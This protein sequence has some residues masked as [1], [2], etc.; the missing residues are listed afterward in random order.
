MKRFAAVWTALVCLILLVC[1]TG[2]H[3]DA[4]TGN[5]T[6]RITLDAMPTNLDP[7]L[8]ESDEALL[9]VRNAFEGLFR[10]DGGEIR[11]AACETWDVSGDGLT[12]TFTL[13]QGLTWSDGSPLTAADFR[14]GLV[15]AL[16]P[17]TKAPNAERLL[18]IV[19][20]PAV[21][22]GAADE[23]T[24]GIEATDDRTLILRLSQRDDS[25]PETLTYAMT[26]PCKESFFLEA[27]GRYGMASK[28]I[29][30]NGPF[31]LSQW[32]ESA[33]R[34][35]RNEHYVGDFPAKPAA[36]VLRFGGMD[37]ERI[38]SVNNDFSDLVSLSTQSA[39]LAEDARL[40]VRQFRD[41]TW[42]ALINPQASVLGDAAVSDAFRTALGTDLLEG[43]LPAQFQPTA[44]LIAGDL[45]VG[46]KRYD[47]LA[48]RPQ[49]SSANPT[50]AKQKL[51]AAL[52]PYGGHLPAI[53]LLYADT[54][55][56][57]QTASHLAQYLQKELGAVV[58]IEARPTAEVVQAVES[59]DYQMALCPF[60]AANGKAQTQLRSIL[61][62]LGAAENVIA[63]VDAMSDLAPDAG[64]E[65]LRRL[66]SQA[67]A[68]SRL[69]PLA[70]SGR[71]FAGSDALTD[72]EPDLAQ[73]LIPLYRAGKHN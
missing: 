4:S 5:K 60:T 10:A 23:A 28:Q 1:G 59:G 45:L 52:K 70:E 73:G 38:E 51:I 14:F 41:T 18:R 11:P 9:L 63:R 26:M 54:D 58:N 33:L 72:V 39:S 61:T 55:G 56:M 37:T 13:R 34:L 7:Q 16:R 6:I 25:L 8:A 69:F 42:L 2:C 19:N 27:A 24:L 30:F 29:L 47:T 68:D 71:C 35:S 49:A 36:V 43:N 21:L 32:D 64:A 20:A 48:A 15:R 46:T 12:Y 66:E 53:T 67:L 65:E 17:E 50:E 62:A 40:S 57:R 31:T 44:G 3:S 22:A